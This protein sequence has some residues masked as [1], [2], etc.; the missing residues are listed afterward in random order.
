MPLQI[1]NFVF[2]AFQVANVGGEIFDIDIGNAVTF[3]WFVVASRFLNFRQF[4]N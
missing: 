2:S 3:V 4:D 1:S